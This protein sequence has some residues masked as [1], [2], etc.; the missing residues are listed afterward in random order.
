MGWLWCSSRGD[1]SS[2]RCRSESTRRG[3][4]DRTLCPDRRAETA[5]GCTM[6]AQFE[7]KEQATTTAQTPAIDTV[8]NQIGGHEGEQQPTVHSLQLAIKGYDL[9]C[10][11]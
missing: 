8:T 10:I 9:A 3:P 5:Q 11:Q 1:S 2:R 7:Y 6:S 4:I